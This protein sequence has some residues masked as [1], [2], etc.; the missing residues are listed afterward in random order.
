MSKGFLNGCECHF[1][2]SEWRLNR[3][4]L[5][6]CNISPQHSGQIIVDA[7]H[8]CFRNWGTENK[9]CSITIDNAKANDLIMTQL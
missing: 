5:N 2:D 1:I 6:F 8:K 3:C 9:I 4:V 7:L